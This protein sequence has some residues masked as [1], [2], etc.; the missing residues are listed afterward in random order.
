MAINIISARNRDPWQLS[1]AKRLL[2]DFSGPYVLE[3]LSSLVV[4]V[5]VLNFGL[6]YSRTETSLA[7]AQVIAQVL[8]LPHREYVQLRHDDEQVIFLSKILEY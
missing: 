5:F 2:K 4:V 6:T 3:L 8:S 1:A 7:Y